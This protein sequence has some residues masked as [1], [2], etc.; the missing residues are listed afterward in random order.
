LPGAAGGSGS[1]GGNG[2]AGGCCSVLTPARVPDGRG[3]C[4]VACRYPVAP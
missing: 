3:Q 4:R 2:V 1:G